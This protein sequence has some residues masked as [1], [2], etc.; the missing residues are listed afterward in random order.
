MSIEAKRVITEDEAEVI[1]ALTED[2]TER[3]IIR[4]M[5]ESGKT[6]KEAFWYVINKK[7]Q[8]EMVE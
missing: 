4:E 3:A 1:K 8:K 6:L 2:E 5:I 7:A